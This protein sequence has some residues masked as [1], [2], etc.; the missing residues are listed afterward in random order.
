MVKFATIVDGR[1]WVYT[2]YESSNCTK[3][4]VLGGKS[5]SISI[6]EFYAEQA[7]AKKHKETYYEEVVS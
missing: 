3:K 2:M 7:E 1:F 4:P 5:T 6:D